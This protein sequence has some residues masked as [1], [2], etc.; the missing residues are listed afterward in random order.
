VTPPVGFNLYVL[1]HVSGQ[2][3]GMVAKNALPFA[4]LLLLGVVLLYL[5]PQIALFLPAQM[6]R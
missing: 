3:I 6:V 4:V 1:Q 2:P 5:F